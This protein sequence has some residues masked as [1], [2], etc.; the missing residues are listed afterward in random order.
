MSGLKRRNPQARNPLRAI[1]DPAGD[2]IPAPVVFGSP[3]L[4]AL[5]QVSRE[6]TPEV[7][8]VMVA[9]AE[10]AEAVEDVLQ[11]LVGED[12]T[13]LDLTGNP[14]KLVS[15]ILANAKDYGQLFGAFGGIIAGAKDILG[16]FRPALAQFLA[17]DQP[18][19]SQAYE[20]FRRELDLDND[21][22][23]GVIERYVVVGFQ[24]I[25]YGDD[26]VR[27]LIPQLVRLIRGGKDPDRG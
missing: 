22:A 16:D 1:V 9:A 11:I 13:L 27:V 18:Q 6:V 3:S 20:L 8:S 23:E 14:L 7:V 17:Y 24:V 19:R 15:R 10:V 25:A 2:G 12:V 21:V 5:S 4:L 26:L